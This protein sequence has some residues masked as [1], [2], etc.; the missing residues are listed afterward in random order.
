MS[1]R[2]TPRGKEETQREERA[3]NTGRAPQEIGSSENFTFKTLTFHLKEIKKE[4]KLN[5][6]P[7]KGRKQ[8]RVESRVTK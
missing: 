6:K 2:R 3:A 5:P 8:S 1:Q 4:S 7:V